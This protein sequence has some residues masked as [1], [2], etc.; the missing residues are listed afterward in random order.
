MWGFLPRGGYIGAK[1]YKI[2]GSWP[3]RERVGWVGS[4]SRKTEQC[5][6]RQKGRKKHHGVCSS[7]NLRYKGVGRGEAGDVV[8][9]ALADQC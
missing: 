9:R 7:L 5:E 1:C 2:S 8:L 6:Q 3:V 4:P